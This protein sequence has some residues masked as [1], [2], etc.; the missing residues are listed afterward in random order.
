MND[1]LELQP[2]SLVYFEEIGIDDLLKA[3]IKVE[4][5]Q[6]SSIVVKSDLQEGQGVKDYVLAVL[7]EVAALK[8]KAF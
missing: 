7:Q 8:L 3:G 5:T 6:G 4:E 2:N 1:K